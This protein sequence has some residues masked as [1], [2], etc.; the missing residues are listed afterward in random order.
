MKILLSLVLIFLICISS[1]TNCYFLIKNKD[2]RTFKVVVSIISLAVVSGILL[3][4]E[5]KGYS[6][7][8]IFNGL[9]QLVK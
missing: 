4:F 2:Y 3:I 5:I 9:S 7:A 8:S 6:I 1:T